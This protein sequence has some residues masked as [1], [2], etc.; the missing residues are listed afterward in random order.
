MML[1]GTPAQAHD[2]Y[3]GKQDPYTHSDCCG[4]KDCHPIETAYRV[5]QSADDR[6]HICVK[7]KHLELKG[8]PEM[9][10]NWLCFFAP[11]HTS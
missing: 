3:T 2:W 1:A 10:L 7:V 6:Y 5:Q 8:R 9:W 4:E 11:L